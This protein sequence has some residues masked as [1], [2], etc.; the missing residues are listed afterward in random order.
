MSTTVQSWRSL[1]GFSN[2]VSLPRL[3]AGIY[4]LTRTLAPGKVI[5]PNNCCLAV[6]YG[7]ILGGA[8]P[9]FCEVNLE[10]ASLDAEA[11]EELLQRTN[12]GMVVHVHSYGI[13]SNRQPIYQ[14]C[15][16]Y[17]A[18]YLEDGASWFPPSRY[19]LLDG[20]CLGLSFGHTKIFELGGGILCFAEPTLA[21]EVEQIV[22]A[23]PD[24]IDL[25]CDYDRIY[26]EKIAWDGLPKSAHPDFLALGEKL[27]A[28]WIGSNRRQISAPNLAQIQRER[29]RRHELTNAFQE[30]L[31]RY[32]IDL[33]RR[34]TLDFV[35]RFSFLSSN[36]WLIQSLLGAS[37]FFVSRWY[38]PLDR[39]FPN[40]ERSRSLR[41]S[42][43]L[44]AGVFNVAL[45][46]DVT[47]EQIFR[48]DQAFRSRPRLQKLLSS[49]KPLV[50]PI[51]D[52][53]R[54]R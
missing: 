20:S 22:D 14:L 17:G 29:E 9:V 7:I 15:K 46:P 10:D 35:W 45:S 11:C 52:R 30:I 34:N 48:A 43:Q 12:A 44:G 47:V 13:Y 41:N 1:L 18:F 5:V 31:S 53:F 27:R 54:K 21:L 2:L 37:D 23:L 42:Y 40:Y 26:R 28:L 16:R 50:G 39:F 38:P 33:F 24:F 32:P 49:V 3:T 51:K 8:E 4:A 19:E 36:R 25:N 6:V